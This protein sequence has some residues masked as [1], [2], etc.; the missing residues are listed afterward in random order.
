[1]LFATIQYP[2][3]DPVA[4]HIGPL[5]IRWYGIAYLLGFALA[6]LI[7]RKL[8]RR[9]TLKITQDA[10][11]DLIG[12]L[13]SGVMVGGRAGWW[14]F[15]HRNTGAPEPWYE[16]FALWHGGMSFHGGL[17]GVTIALVLWSWL[18][19]APLLNVSDC[20]ALVTPVG[21]FFGR[22]ANFINAELVGRSTAL[23]W[24]VVFPGDTVPRHPSQLY[25]AL[26]EGPVLLLALWLTFRWRRARDGRIAALFLILYGLFRFGVEFTREP[27]SQL[28]F[29]AFGW[30]TM[31]QLLSALLMVAGGTLWVFLSRIASVTIRPTEAQVRSAGSD[32]F[33]VRK[34]MIRHE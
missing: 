24:G 23:P 22:I 19:H 20:A 1:M 27:D 7:L 3:L 26:L 9:G 29:I 5:A 33:R 10:L 28:G 12:W 31:G 8:I 32:V 25:E 30:L 11:G 14:L 17:I 15:Y 13:V 4:L 18:R 34:E 16:P 2:R 6:Y 21:L